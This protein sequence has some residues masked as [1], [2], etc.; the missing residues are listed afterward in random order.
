MPAYSFSSQFADL[1]ESGE[2]R[3][4][5]RRRRK[6]QTKVGDMLYLYAGMRTKS[7]RKL[8]EAVCTAVTP[9]RIVEG[10]VIFWLWPGEERHTLTVFG[11]GALQALAERDGFK[12]ASEFFTW[13]DEQYGLP[14]TGELIQW[15]SDT[16]PRMRNGGG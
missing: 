9:I 10:A 8:G 11:K 6:R 13:F 7:C 15:C 2:K 16:R 12:T 14:F 3:Q 5:I 4:T 1:V